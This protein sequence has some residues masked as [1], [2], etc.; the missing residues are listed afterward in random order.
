[1]TAVDAQGHELW[2][3]QKIDARFNFS[4]LHRRPGHRQSLAA[5]LRPHG[6][7]GPKSGNVLSILDAEKQT[8]S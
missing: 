2:E 6:E 1:M 4:D 5:V 8:K 3:K 7:F